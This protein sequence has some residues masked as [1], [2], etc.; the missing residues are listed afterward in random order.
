M[1]SRS[2]SNI[3]ALVGPIHPERVNLARVIDDD[4]PD[5]YPTRASSSFMCFLHSSG[6]GDELFV[7]LDY[8]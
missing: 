8:Y 7:T 4:D 3:S 1:V 5:L 6:T 2:L